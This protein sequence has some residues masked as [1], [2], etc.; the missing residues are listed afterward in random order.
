MAGLS[1]RSHILEHG[2][3]MADAI[4]FATASRHDA[5]IVTND[6]D[7]DGLPGVTLIR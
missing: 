7:F 3:A 4:L 2:L 6:V 5:Q 1:S